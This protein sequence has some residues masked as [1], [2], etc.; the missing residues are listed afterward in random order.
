MKALITGITG[1]DGSYLA[2]FLLSK[3]YE[4]F[5]MV[6]RSSTEKFDRI[7]HIIDKIKLKQG[8]LLDQLSLIRL[9]EEIQPEEVYNLAAQSFVPTSWQQPVLT[10]EF[11]AV[12]VTRILEAIH[13]V[14]KKIKFYQASSSEMFG[15]TQEVP[16]TEKTPFYPRSP[17]GVAKVYGHWITVNYRES[18]GIFGCSG[19]LFNHESPRRGLEFVTRKVTDG[20]AKIKLGLT[21]KLYLGNLDAQRDWGYAGDYVESMWLML[22]QKEP[23]NYVVATGIS[24]SVKDLVRVAFESAGLDWQKY[25][26]VDQNL[27]RPA[28]VDHLLGDAS[29]AKKKLGWKP[30]VSFEQM[31][32]MMVEHDLALQQKILKHKD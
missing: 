5:G 7:N 2:E 24:H 14:N 12:G 1:Q 27:V 13:Q 28:E 15:K 8:D 20:V 4:V 9:I 26:K 23:D 16:Q 30:K 25:V 22:Q 3:G 29:Y 6:R 18:Y 32:K 11:D 19:I 31:I 21:D 10:A 17:Y